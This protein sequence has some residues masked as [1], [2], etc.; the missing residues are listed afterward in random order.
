[1][2]A[3]GADEIRPEV[4]SNVLDGIDSNGI[5][6]VC[7]DEGFNPCVVRANNGGVFGVDI[8][9]CDILVAEPACLYLR[10]VCVILDPAEVVEVA[11]SDVERAVCGIRLKVS[12]ICCGDMIDNLRNVSNRT[13]LNR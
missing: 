13:V 5:E 1:M 2:Y 10:L 11:G 12:G 3:G 7:R 6:A 8:G 4:L 9:K